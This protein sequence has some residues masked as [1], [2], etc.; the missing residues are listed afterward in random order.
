MA[1]TGLAFRSCLDA[2][3]RTGRLGRHIGLGRCGDRR[4]PHEH[5]HYLC[6]EFRLPLFVVAFV[7]QPAPSGLG[8]DR[9]RVPLGL[10]PVN[11]HW[12]AA[13]FGLGE[14]AD[15][16]VFDLGELCSRA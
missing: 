3:T 16:A 5:H 15:R 11:V 1:A 14:L 4:G 13:I 6:G 9:S 10:G 2:D 8:A 12:A 7:F